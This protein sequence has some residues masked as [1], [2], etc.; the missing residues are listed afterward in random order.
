MADTVGRFVSRGR[1]AE[2]GGAGG[3]GPAALAEELVKLALRLGSTDNIT[4][5]VVAFAYE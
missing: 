4:V 5:A 1:L 3:G 2:A